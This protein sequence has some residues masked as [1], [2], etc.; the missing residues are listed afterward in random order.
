MSDTH[1]IFGLSLA[2]AKVY[3]E[4]RIEFFQTNHPAVYTTNINK[5]RLVIAR[6]NSVEKLAFGVSNFI[7]AHP[8][9]NLKKI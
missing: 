8:S 4:K 3:L 6:A 2:D 1:K 9:E 7:L 5:A